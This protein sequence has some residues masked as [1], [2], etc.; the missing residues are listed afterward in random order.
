MPNWHSREKGTSRYTGTMIADITVPSEEDKAMEKET[1]EYIFEQWFPK[2]PDASLNT[3]IDSTVNVRNV[4]V[5]TH[6]QLV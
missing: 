4:E 5:E 2:N 1:A 6:G 3:A